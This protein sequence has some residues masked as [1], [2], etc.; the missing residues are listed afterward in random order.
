MSAV[1]QCNYTVR[2]AVSAKGLRISH[3]SRIPLVYHS[4][5]PVAKFCWVRGG[6]QSACLTALSGQ[7][8]RCEDQIGK[9]VLRSPWVV[10]IS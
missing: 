9:G 8:C 4:T 10:T 2:G 5:V 3:A 7:R 6:S 1:A